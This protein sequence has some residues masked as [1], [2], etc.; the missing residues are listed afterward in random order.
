MSTKVP[1]LLSNES[2][3]LGRL[4]GMDSCHPFANWTE[5][6]QLVI[7]WHRAWISRKSACVGLM[8]KHVKWDIVSILIG[9][10]QYANRDL[11]AST[12][13]PRSW[14]KRLPI[15]LKEMQCTYDHGLFNPL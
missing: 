3:D 13:S 15:G 1:S 2:S 14:K 5:A 9:H 12:V 11:Q 6:F 10:F 7:S 8:A 4:V